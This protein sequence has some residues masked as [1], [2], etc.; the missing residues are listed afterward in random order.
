MLSKITQGAQKAVQQVSRFERQVNNLKARGDIGQMV[1]RA[2]TPPKFGDRNGFEDFNRDKRV[3]TTG[4]QAQL[5][6]AQ[7]IHTKVPRY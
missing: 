2:R 7:M 5:V 4:Y 3:N 1:N 6:K